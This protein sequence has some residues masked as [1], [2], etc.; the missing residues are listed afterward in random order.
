MYLHVYYSYNEDEKLL[1]CNNTAQIALEF[2]NELFVYKTQNPIAFLA[3]GELYRND[4][5]ALTIVAPNGS[6]RAVQLEPETQSLMALG[7]YRLH[8]NNVDII[9]QSSARSALGQVWIGFRIH[10]QNPSPVQLTLQQCELINGEETCETV[11]DFCLTESLAG[12]SHPNTLV[13]NTSMLADCGQH[14]L[15]THNTEY[16]ATEISLFTGT[17]EKPIGAFWQLFNEGSPIFT[18]LH[19]PLSDEQ[20]DRVV[21]GLENVHTFRKIDCHRRRSHVLIG[22]YFIFSDNS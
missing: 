21:V 15:Y 19:Y 3:N 18:E 5:N 1:D 13:L 6:W 17:S 9:K 16:D 11:P 8:G 20:S 4:A 2:Q 12:D 10:N 14:T 22:D 7:F